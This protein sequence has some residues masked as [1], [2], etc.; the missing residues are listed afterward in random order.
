MRNTAKMTYDYEYHRVLLV[1]E[2][3]RLLLESSSPM[4]H[5][6]GT[7]MSTKI[8]Y[9]DA[10]GGM[11]SL[12]GPILKN[13]ITTLIVQGSYFTTRTTVA[14]NDLSRSHRKISK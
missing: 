10:Y 3:P 2:K 9:R 1:S 14:E 11:I 12:L 7:V 8:R 5:T 6:H 13:P 4:S